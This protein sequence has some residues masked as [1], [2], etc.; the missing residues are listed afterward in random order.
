ML[1]I[2]FVAYVYPSSRN[3]YKGGDDLPTFLLEV[4]NCDICQR[5]KQS[6]K[7]MVN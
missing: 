3:G 4:N 5:T 6:N 7:N 2:I 1:H